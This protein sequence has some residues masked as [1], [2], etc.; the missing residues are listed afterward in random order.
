MT[1]SHSKYEAELIISDGVNV[2]SAY[3]KTKDSE[4]AYKN[5][6]ARKLYKLIERGLKGCTSKNGYPSPF[7]RGTSIT[8]NVSKQGTDFSIEKFE[9]SICGLEL[10]N[11]NEYVY[12]EYKKEGEMLIPKNIPY[13]KLASSSISFTDNND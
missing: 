6:D 4:K 13:I 2:L 5:K 7:V 12:M 3:K 9:D 10:S 8:H 1:L 11:D